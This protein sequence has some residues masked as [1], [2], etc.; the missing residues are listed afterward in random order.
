[1]YS[2]TIQKLIDLFSKFPTIGPRTAARF[3]FY[4]MHKPKEEIEELIISVSDLKKNIKICPL[5]LNPYEGE[6]ELCSICSDSRRDRSL[7]CIVGNETD[8][9]AIEKTKKYQGLYFILGGTVSR[10][11]KADIEKLK[12]KELEKRIKSGQEIKEIILAL[13][14]TAEGE[15]TTLYLERLLR[16]LNKKITR[17][18]RGLPLGGELEYADEETLSSALESRR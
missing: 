18:G 11:K 16:P 12:I 1:M 4:L 17:L 8:L 5:C 7:L 3:V 2:P 10:L 14:P 15:A 9:T 13:N 6:A